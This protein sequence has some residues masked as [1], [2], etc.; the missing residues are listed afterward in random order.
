[1]KEN[2]FTV[3]LGSMK[4]TDAERI[5][6]NSAIQK[7]V[8]NEISGLGLK[9]RVALVPINKWIK[10]PIINGIIVRELTERDLG[11]FVKMH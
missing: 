4:L 6:I 9:N 2:K 3:D 10:G 11:S 1:M 5:K 8:V 7:A